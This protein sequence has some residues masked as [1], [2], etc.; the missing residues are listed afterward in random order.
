MVI[1]F[2]RYLVFPGLLLCAAL[3]CAQPVSNSVDP[4]FASDASASTQLPYVSVFTN[5]RSFR[6]Q[7]LFSWQESNETAGKIGGWRFYAREATRPENTSV[8]GFRPAAEKNNQPSTDL[9]PGH[10]KHRSTP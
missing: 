10:Q 8:D 3:A 5:Y 6:E 7:P 9:N 4:A 1:H 2:L